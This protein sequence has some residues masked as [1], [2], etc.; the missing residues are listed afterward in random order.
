MSISLVGILSIS[1]L[2]IR[3][4]DTDLFLALFQRLI[5][6]TLPFKKSLIL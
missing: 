5:K 6:E 3:F 4:L 1:D 2:G